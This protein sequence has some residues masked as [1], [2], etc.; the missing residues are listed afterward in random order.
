M[1][2]LVKQLVVKYLSTI[3]ENDQSGGEKQEKTKQKTQQHGFAVHNRA[4]T[5]LDFIIAMHPK[6]STCS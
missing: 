2:S 6:H 4:S 5:V 3:I 1:L